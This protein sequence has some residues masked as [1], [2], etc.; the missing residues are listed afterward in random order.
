MLA[1]SLE[2]G[3]SED[4]TCESVGNSG[5]LERHNTQVYEQGRSFSGNERDK[6]YFNRGDGTFA[7]LSDLSGCDNP[8]DGR[9]TIGCDFD[10]DGDVDLFVH[11]LQ[12]ERHTLYRNEL[13]TTHGGFLK[14][15]LRATQGH[16]EAIG[17]TVLVDGPHGLMAQVLSRGAGFI[18]CQAPELIFG[19][20]EAKN[21]KVQILWPGGELEDFG[22]LQAN[23]R[24]L[25]VQGSGTSEPVAALTT[26]LP[27]PLPTGLK[28][29]PGVTASEWTVADADGASTRLRLTDLAQGDRLMV[30]LW[31]SYCAPCVAELGYLQETDEREGVRLICL[32]V[33]SPAARA[34]A[35]SL[36]SKRAP[37]LT[38]YYLPD[39]IAPDSELAELLDLQ[40]L[41]LPT[42]LV[43]DA[44]G[45][46]EGI[47]QGPL[48]QGDAR[49]R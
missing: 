16:W 22:T 6:L 14:L 4:V 25:L 17:A 21:A 30:N 48:E 29:Q 44:T 13:G 9:A 47:V 38:G 32:S 10:D 20:G 37:N 23:S 42:T 36:L 24:N 46:L 26:R 34:Q 7:D 43:F 40:R 31:A 5:Y 28:V 33:D 1:S 11:Q 12:R 41:P 35:S 8:N 2:S 19:L 15:R 27:D 18:S 39:V 45:K 49:W 3:C